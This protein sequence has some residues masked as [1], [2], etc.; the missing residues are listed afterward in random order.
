[1]N[2]DELRGFIADLREP[3]NPML[4]LYGMYRQ[5]IDAG[6]TEAQAMHLV[7]AA[8]TASISGAMGR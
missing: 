8:L 2:E 5:M 7:T 3:V 1:M 4:E 6:F